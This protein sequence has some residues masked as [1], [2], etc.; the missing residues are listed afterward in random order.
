MR[1]FD[2][3]I[4]RKNADEGYEIDSFVSFVLFLQISF[5]RKSDF[6]ILTN[7]H[8]VY[9]RDKR[10]QI[11]HA[12]KSN[13]WILILRNTGYNDSGIYE[14]QVSMNIDNAIQNGIYLFNV[15]SYISF[16]SVT[17]KY[18]RMRTFNISIFVPKL[19][20]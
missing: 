18:I 5:I 16:D 6:H 2:L 10:F 8:T 17:D 19:I 12:A 9:T 20:L 11:F 13:D 1:V 15:Y 14:C 4:I 7:G 3:I